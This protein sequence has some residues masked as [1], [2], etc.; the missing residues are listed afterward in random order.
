MEARSVLPG[1]AG[2]ILILDLSTNSFHE[3]PV[4]EEMARDYIG[5]T[6]LSARLACEYATPGAEALSPENVIVLGAGVLGGTSVPGT[7]KTSLVTKFPMTGAF[8]I[9]GGGG[10]FGLMLKQAGY[11][12]LVITGRA[13]RPVYLVIDKEPSIQ[14][15]AHLW[16]QDIFETTEFLWRQYGLCSVLAAGQAAEKLVKISLAYIDNMGTLGRGGFGAILGAKN[17]KAIVARPSRGI[18]V[19]NKKDL[20]EQIDYVVKLINTDPLRPTWLKDGVKIG[21]KSWVK[22]DFSYKDWKTVFPKERA[23]K[24]YESDRFHDIIEKRTPACGTCPISDKSVYTIKKGEFAGETCYASEFLPSMLSFGIKCNLG[25]DYNKMMKCTDLANRYGID[26]MS[27]S[28]LLAFAVQLYQE[29]ILT[30]DDTGGIELDLN[31]ETVV[32]VLGQIARR[33]GIGDILAEGWY[34]AIERIGRGCEKYATHIKGLEPSHAEART[35]LNP[36]AFESVVNPRVHPFHAEC[37]SI[38][39]QRTSDKLWRHCARIGVPEEAVDRI[40]DSPYG[41]NIARLARYNED[42]F[43]LFSS[44]GICGRQ[45]IVERYGSGVFRQVYTAV[46]GWDRDQSDLMRVGERAWNLIR[47]LNYREGFDRKDDKYP[48][49]WFEPIKTKDGEIRLMDYYRTEEMTRE[50]MEGL[51]NDYYD[52]RGWDQ[53]GGVPTAAKLEELGLGDLPAAVPGAGRAGGKE[54]PR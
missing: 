36:E 24:L 21:W 54:G 3:R 40:F 11:D 14:D 50:F 8:G 32:K 31:F 43:A 19:A 53:A 44:L 9:G 17:L 1:Y 45:Q 16:G 20:L 47:F 49:V 6:A 27:F 39:P 22:V 12:Q 48:D 51:L 25:D 10:N 2:K 28:N 42:W 52:E 30:K 41:F 46:T 26:M 37:P 4:T 35:I 33:E 13:D 23:A 18:K 5:G 38:L 15:A 34:G 7:A 29:G